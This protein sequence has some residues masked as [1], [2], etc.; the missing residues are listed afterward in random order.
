MDSL[1]SVS[2]LDGTYRRRHTDWC[3]DAV[4]LYA[5]LQL[6]DRCLS[7]CVSLTSCRPSDAVER[8]LTPVIPALPQPSQ[9]TSCSDL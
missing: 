4:H 1:E 8:K 2:P 3:W 6:L 5:L 7:S 9:P